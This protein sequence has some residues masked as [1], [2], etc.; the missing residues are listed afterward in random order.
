MAYEKL[1]LEDGQVLTADHVNHIEDGIVAAD[2]EASKAVKTINEI[3][4]DENG[5]VNVSLEDTLAAVEG[6]KVGQ[7][8]R[9]SAV[10]EAGKVT[11][12]EAV[13][14]ADVEMPDGTRLSELSTA[15]NVVEGTTELQPD[16]YHVFG[17]VSTL[18]VTLVEAD[19]GKAHEYCFEFIP[20]EGFSGLEVTPAPRWAVDPDIEVGK[21]YQV[22]ILRG[23][24]V[25]AG[26]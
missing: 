26:A 1:N 24:G 10:D 12:V 22:S 14:A 25:I 20:A 4:P 11:A 6:A 2:E 23:I 15:P 7:L 19:D 5:N 21:T 18:S 3:V 9:V 17:E 8:I 13:D 16:T